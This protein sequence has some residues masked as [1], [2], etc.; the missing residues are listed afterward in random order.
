MTMKTNNRQSGAST[1]VLVAGIAFLVLP[2]IG[3]FVFEVNRYQF[4]QRQLEKIVD[5]AAL[6][7]GTRMVEANTS[8]APQDQGVTAQRWRHEQGIRAAEEFIVKPDPSK[9]TQYIYSVGLH[10]SSGPGHTDTTPPGQPLTNPSGP[11]QCR[12][13][14]FPADPEQDFAEV[15]LGDE[16][17]RAIAVRAIYNEN[18]MLLR[19]IGF[20]A[21]PV[22][23]LSNSGSPRVDVVLALDCSGSMDDSTRV[24]LI[25]QVIKLTSNGQ[26]Q[27]E[28]HGPPPPPPDPSSYDSCNGQCG[29][30]YDS[31][32][33]NV[34]NG[35]TS[36]FATWKQGFDQKRNANLYLAYEPTAIGK[37]DDIART[38]GLTSPS[39]TQINVL[40]HRHPYLMRPPYVNTSSPLCWKENP[41]NEIVASA[42]PEGDFWRGPPYQSSSSFGKGR[43]GFDVMVANMNSLVARNKAT[44]PKFL[45][46]NR[47]DNS[48]PPKANDKFDPGLP[49]G[50]QLV[51][52]VL[53]NDPGAAIPGFMYDYKGN[54]YHFKN[55]PTL[56]EASLG[57]LDNGNGWE[58]K[59]QSIENAIESVVGQIPNGSLLQN[60]KQEPPLNGTGLAS[61][62]DFKKAYEDAAKKVLEPEA[63]VLD[64]AHQ[65]IAALAGS[66]KNM[67]ISLVTY[68]GPSPPFS[69]E[70]GVAP[71]PVKY[72][73]SPP[74]IGAQIRELTVKSP[75]EEDRLI[76]STALLPTSDKACVDALQK[77][78]DKSYPLRT[79]D[80]ANALRRAKEIIDDARGGQNARRAKPVIVLL[81]DGRHSDN[82]ENPVT[83][84]QGWGAD[85][86]IPVYCI[87]LAQ[88]DTVER[89]MLDELGDGVTVHPTIGRVGYGISFASGNGARYYQAPSGEELRKVLLALARKLVTLAQ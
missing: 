74:A 84:V 42:S 53:G 58:D 61:K 40:A 77:E 15:P 37:L 60:T 8:G 24:S 81:T 28:Q 41:T 46:N 71:Q 51:R 29:G 44:Y 21:A 72:N 34:Y 22:T 73:N 18:P 63:T 30:A 82:T 85:A 16:R 25:G 17:G 35:Y 78:L 9:A 13:K 12:I 66:G 6:A 83:V 56:V 5:A 49:S 69:Q 70:P 47:Q 48:I 87:G 39:G 54:S 80:T 2:L 1:I 52:E 55:I 31:C 65:F 11:D 19:Y 62:A 38:G 26:Q 27:L 43:N 32:V 89:M 88:N 20:N 67:R 64:A 45:F 68:D 10:A 57:T 23:V 4:V 75:G 33:D 76:I 3:L 36:Q 79:T 59:V 14:C 86:G 50:D 7:G